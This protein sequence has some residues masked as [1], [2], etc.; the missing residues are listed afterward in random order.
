MSISNCRSTSGILRPPFSN[1]HYKMNNDN[2]SKGIYIYDQLL[3]LL[4][5]LNQSWLATVCL[6]GFVDTHKRSSPRKLLE[7]S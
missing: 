4:R 5:D 7:I 3:H 6:K 1:L 2:N